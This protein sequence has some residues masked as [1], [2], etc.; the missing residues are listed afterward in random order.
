MSYAQNRDIQKCENMV[1]HL[2][3]I[4]TSESL[5]YFTDI[6]DVNIFPKLF[7]AIAVLMLREKQGIRDLTAELSKII[8]QEESG[9]TTKR[10]VN[11]AISWLQESHIIGYAAKST[12][13]DYLQ[14]KENCRNSSMVRAISENEGRTGLSVLAE[15]KYRWREEHR[16]QD[17][18]SPSVS[19]R[20][21]Q[22]QSGE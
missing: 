14:V 4:F 22:F 17:L 19:G 16:R 11:H 18:Y 12:D 15:R 10:M 3:D 9:R 2:I 8:Y 6:A 21:D 7:Q 13:C 20:Q 5:R 1:E